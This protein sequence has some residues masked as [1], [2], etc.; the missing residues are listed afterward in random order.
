MVQIINIENAEIGFKNFEGREG[1]YNKEGVRSFAV[2]FDHDVAED[3]LKEGWNI[4][5]P[6]P[7]DSID[8]E[9]DTRKPFMQVSVSFDNYPASVFMVSNENVTRLGE[10][11]VSMLDWAEIQNV[12]LVIRPYTWSVNGNSG[13]KAYLKAGYF[14]IVTDKFAEKYGL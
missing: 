2:F 6:R 3:L 14:T 9:E 11:E 4:K 13:I 10:E 1:A 8:P 12:D 7:M 5:F